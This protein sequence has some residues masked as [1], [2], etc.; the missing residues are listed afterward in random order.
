MAQKYCCKACDYVYNPQKGDREGGVAPGVAFEV[1]SCLVLWIFSLSAQLLIC[2][3][4]HT[5][6]S[7]VR[8]MGSNVMALWSPFT[9]E[10][11]SSTECHASEPQPCQLPLCWVWVHPNFSFLPSEFLL[12]IVDVLS[13]RQFLIRVIQV[14][15]HIREPKLNLIHTPRIIQGVL[16]LTNHKKVPHTLASG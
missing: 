6:L 1:E 7:D 13:H 15:T 5:S 3:G 14:Y 8:P 12:G 4:P 9:C 11:L 16:T 2:R 10:H